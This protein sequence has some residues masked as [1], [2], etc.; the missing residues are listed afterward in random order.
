[1]G[2]LSRIRDK[3]SDY[4]RRL[5]SK[6]KDYGRKVS[7][8]LAKVQPYLAG[9]ATFVT[10]LVGQPWIGAA[11]G[12][13]ESAVAAPYLGSTAAR[14]EGKKGRDAREE[15]R[16]QRKKVAIAA[17]G[18][19]AA[20]FL[21]NQVVIPL[22]KSSAAASSAAAATA[23]AAKGASVPVTTLPGGLSVSSLLAATS[24]S[25]PAVGAA[26]AAASGLSVT[27]VL[28]TLGGI[29]VPILNAYLGPKGTAPGDDGFLDGLL[30]GLGLG[31]GGGSGSPGSGDVSDPGSNNG[32][33][34]PQPIPTWVKVAGGGA[35]LVGG[36][37]AIKALRKAA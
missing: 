14:A 1:M 9:G 23:V 11:L 27:G 6:T 30:S 5:Q 32:F 7:K 33:A 37:F 10:T 29:G 18:G 31:G 16:D 20:G 13:F 2:I 12:A 15:G 35:V 24:G 19:W 34:T 21:G 8:P 4:G 17:A 26:T 36:Y 28:T 3:A 22:V 25:A